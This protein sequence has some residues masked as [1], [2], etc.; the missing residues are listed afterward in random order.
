M[1]WILSD[2]YFP[3]IMF[4][5][6]TWVYWAMGIVSSLF[7]SLSIF[8]HEYGHALA[9]RAL[10]LPLE[11]IHLYLFGGMAELKQRPMRPVEEMLIALAGPVASLLFAGAAWGLSQVIHQDHNEAFLVLQFV[12][13]MNL[14]LCGFNLLPIFPLDGG[15]ALRAVLWHFKRY[16]Y[17]A[18]ILTYYI[19][20]GIIIGLL[21]ITLVLTFIEGFRTSFWAALLAG[22][23]WYTAYS[24]R[25]E[26]IYRPRFEDLVFRIHEKR[27][28]A[29]IIRQ[30]NRIDARYLP[31]AVIPV[32]SNGELESVVLGRD[33]EKLPENEEPLDHL[34]RPVE[35]GYF[36]DVEDES[37]Y[38]PG[39]SLKA[40]LLPVLKDG[41][42]LGMS[43]A[44]EI[45]FWLLQHKSVIFPPQNNEEGLA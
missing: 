25:D 11:R 45:R 19:S 39:V 4:T 38:K 41:T 34:Y 2:R 13:Y 14:L 5:Q 1:A 37:T 36:V 22:Y 6:A 30:I 33:I 44:N 31:N 26:L 32:S 42:I 18:S 24:G 16:F 17:K 8:F 21:V 35:R 10:K 28:P 29:S 40:D 43:D 7:L 27:S 3:Q 9:A 20:I 15:R 23:L 12:F